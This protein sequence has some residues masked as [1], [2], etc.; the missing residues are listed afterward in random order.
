LIT[1]R[2]TWPW[3]IAVW[4]SHFEVAPAVRPGFIGIGM[5]VSAMSC[6]E[7]SSRQDQWAVGV[8]WPCVEGQHVFHG[9]Y[10]RIVGLWRD[11][12]ALAAKRFEMVFLSVRPIVESLALDETE[13]HN[14]VLQKPQGPTPASLGRL[15]RCQDRT[16]PGGPRRLFL[17]I[18]VPIIKKGLPGL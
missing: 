15:I 12:Q 17:E 14:L 13:F 8:M 2:S 18:G 9:G 6:L 10:K 16:Q 3:S 5:R 11:D 7:V 1:A 4:I